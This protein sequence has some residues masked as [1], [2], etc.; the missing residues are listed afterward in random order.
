MICFRSRFYV[1]GNFQ[2]SVGWLGDKNVENIRAQAVKRSAAAV[3][4][5]IIRYRGECIRTSS[6]RGGGRTARGSIIVGIS[7]PSTTGLVSVVLSAYF[8]G[9][10][11]VHRHPH[12]HKTITARTR[13]DVIATT[14]LPLVNRIYRNEFREM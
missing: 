10:L 4:Q 5:Y 1:G 6:A 14:Y 7:A 2:T 13:H 9:S 11:K 3:L 12:P 8:S